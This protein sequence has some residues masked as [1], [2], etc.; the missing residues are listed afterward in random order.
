MHVRTPTAGFTL[1]EVLIVILIIGILAVSVFFFL[2]EGRKSAR[3]AVRRA[4]IDNLE[5]SL[6]LYETEHDFIYPVSSLCL[7]ANGHTVDG[8]CDSASGEDPWIPGLVERYIDVMPTDPGSHA[9]STMNRYVYVSPFGTYRY[10]L[11]YFPEKQAPDDPCGLGI[12]G[13]TTQCESQ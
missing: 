13:L 10:V 8:Q 12:A 2:N 7:A 4:D 3:D 11:G 6:I 9:D 1:A 5:K